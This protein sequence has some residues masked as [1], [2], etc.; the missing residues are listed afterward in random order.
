MRF[1]TLAGWLAWQ[2]TLHPVE[3][4]LGLSRVRLV[5][6]VLGCGGAPAFPILTVAGAN[7]NRE[8]LGL[9]RQGP[10]VIDPERTLEDLP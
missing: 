6:E 2:E 3:M 8:V 1:D 5:H 9:F 10:L 4:D 7:G